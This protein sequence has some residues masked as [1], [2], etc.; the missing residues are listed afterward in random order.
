VKS[1]AT[2]H[3][4]PCPKGHT[5][6]YVKRP[7]QCAICQRVASKKYRYSL[8]GRHNESGRPGGPNNKG[9][10]SADEVK[11][12]ER[13]LKERRPHKAIAEVIGRSALAV[14]EKVHAMGLGRK[15]GLL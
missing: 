1:R 14:L 13:L 12:L 8:A 5:E 4:S 10:W 2:F 15:A 7:S 6:R 9:R 3:G 11:T